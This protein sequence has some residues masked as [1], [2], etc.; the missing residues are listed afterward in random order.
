MTDDNDSV[1]RDEI[2]KREKSPSP[3]MANAGESSVNGQASRDDG[4]VILDANREVRVKL[5]MGRVSCGKKP[6]SS[7]TPKLTRME[8]A[9]VFMGWF[10]FI[11]TFHMPHPR[12]SAPE[13]TT[14]VLTKKDIDFPLG[15]GS[16]IVDVSVTMQWCPE[17]EDD[18]EPP[19][20]T[21]SVD[22]VQGNGEPSG[23]TM[24]TLQA[25]TSGQM[26][27]MVEAKQAAED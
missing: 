26:G 17:G 20:R 14:W 12:S 15:V 9:Q 4:G 21:G 11:P 16:S 3:A 13:P 24:A 2:K 6:S 10:W 25:A 19:V 27:V 1:I 8:L 22:S 18:L 23:T 7:S 5:Y